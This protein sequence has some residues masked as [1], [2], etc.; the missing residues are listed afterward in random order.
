MSDYLGNLVART[1]SPTVGVR[2]QLLSVF[3]PPPTNSE[4]KV[5]LDFNPHTS[6][7]SSPVAP[8]DANSL[9]PS[10]TLPPSV[11][12]PAH[13]PLI[14]TPQPSPPEEVSPVRDETDAAP[15][16]RVFS[17]FGPT[18]RV[19][20]EPPSPRED[21]G[22][23]SVQPHLPHRASGAGRVEP[24]GER[25]ASPLPL[26][27]S[28][29]PRS[30]PPPHGANESRAPREDRGVE[31]VEPRPPRSGN[32]VGMTE[33][34]GEGRI[35]ALPSRSSIALEP[36]MVA[37]PVPPRISTERTADR[38][39]VILEPAAAV[40]AEA[41]RYESIQSPA[42][43][44]VMPA[45]RIFPP[46]VPPAAAVVPPTIH[47]T[48]GRVE[49]RAT[50]PPAARARPQAAGAPVMTLEEYLRQRASGGSR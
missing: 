7:E 25:R 9:T 48:I 18:P 1:L 24:A 3:E 12:Q 22:L 45:D 40:D 50:P 19:V 31:A 15:P 21:W 17:Q 10:I 11:R 39:A 13:Q 34:A 27:P 14:P 47:V 43:R 20:D 4:F 6:T 32:G 41:P 42:I 16:L 38:P 35:N 29:S 26:R 33:P 46:H 37:A 30:G 23:E 2:P 8:A 28:I 49:V 44:P 5:P 36:I